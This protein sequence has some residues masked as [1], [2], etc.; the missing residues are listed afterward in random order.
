MRDG[1]EVGGSFLNVWFSIVC[2]VG[3]GYRAD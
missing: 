1:K 3:N 2:S